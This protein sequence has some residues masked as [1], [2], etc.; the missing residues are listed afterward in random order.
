MPWF[1]SARKDGESVDYT[2]IN[3]GYTRDARMNNLGTDIMDRDVEI[4]RS[5]SVLSHSD[6]S[7]NNSDSKREGSHMQ[8][9]SLS[10]IDKT[11]VSYKGPEIDGWPTAPYKLKGSSIPV[12]VGDMLLI[13]LPI[14]FIGMFSRL[15][16]RLEAR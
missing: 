11:Y 15:C 13:V 1:L 2:A 4:G 9:S 14:A 5:R 3:S 10:S 6:L 7:A 16:G 8:E 12:F